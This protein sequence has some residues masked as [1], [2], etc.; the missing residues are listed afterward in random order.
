L[1]P[2]FLTLSINMVPEVNTV[3]IDGD[4]RQ[5]SGIGN[6]NFSCQNVC[7]WLSALITYQQQAA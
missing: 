2:D 7:F 6:C 4:L 3:I 5:L 1:T